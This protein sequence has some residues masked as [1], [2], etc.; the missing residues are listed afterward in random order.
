M[1][2]TIDSADAVL[3]LTRWD[4]FREVPELFSK[5]NKKPEFINGRRMLNKTTKENYKGI[6]LTTKEN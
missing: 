5:M 1:N 4:K 3:L 6:G 2:E